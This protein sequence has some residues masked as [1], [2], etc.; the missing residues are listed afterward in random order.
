MSHDKD[1]DYGKIATYNGS[2]A[3]IRPDTGERDIFA[4]V[5][6]L[7]RHGYISPGDRVSYILAKDT[8]KPGR[9]LAKHVHLI[10]SERQP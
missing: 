2:Y 9:L 4:H 1:R 7:P 3:F 5:S 6:E 10:D 8:H